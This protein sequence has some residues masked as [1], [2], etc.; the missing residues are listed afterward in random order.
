MTPVLLTYPPSTNR[1]WRMAGGRMIQ[2]AEIK[3]WKRTA[4]ITAMASGM[5]ALAGPVAVD[6]TLHPKAT[7][8]GLA[9]KTRLDL[10]N[11]LKLS[12]DALNGIGYADDKQ[13]VRV[14]AA[15]GEPITDGGLTVAVT[16]FVQ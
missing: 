12:L 7:K 14:S 3:A 1:A 15:I 5:R 16:P 10:D 2:P 11:V 4:G 13:I 9:S 6:V 8:A